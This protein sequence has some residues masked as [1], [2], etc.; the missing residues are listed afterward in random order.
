MLGAKLSLALRRY[1]R[2]LFVLGANLIL[3]DIAHVY[4]ALAVVCFLPQ[5]YVHRCSGY[6]SDICDISVLYVYICGRIA[7]MGF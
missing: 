4:P 5:S 3:E 1:K 6:G 7:K 2:T